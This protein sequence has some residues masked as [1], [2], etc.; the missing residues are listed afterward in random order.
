M[1]INHK[2][3]FNLPVY[4]EDNEFL[5]YIVGLEIDTDT[6]VVVTYYVSKHKL[7]TEL[8]SSLVRDSSLLVSSKQVVSI[9]NERMIVQSTV[10]PIESIQTVTASAPL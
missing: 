4:T 1:R 8:L 7:V 9:T 6:H 5:G 10:V 3:L 2:Q